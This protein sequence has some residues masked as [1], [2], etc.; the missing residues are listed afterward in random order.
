[1]NMQENP[2]VNFL[3]YF[4]FKFKKKRKRNSIG[5]G[6]KRN[7]RRRSLYVALHHGRVQ[8]IHYQR[9]IIQER[10]V[11]ASRESLFCVCVDV[12]KQKKKGKIV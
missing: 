5:R 3:L 11:T 6:E 12:T 8:G 9:L 7:G 10:L 4:F 1:M 2:G